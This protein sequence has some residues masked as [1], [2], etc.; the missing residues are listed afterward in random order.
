M[1]TVVALSMGEGEGE[2]GMSAG[3]GR[4]GLQQHGVMSLVRFANW[5]MCLKLKTNSSL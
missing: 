1:V 3:W 5:Y 2:W 4:G